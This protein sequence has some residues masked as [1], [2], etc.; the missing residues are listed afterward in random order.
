LITVSADDRT[1][2][3]LEGLLDL[4][5]QTMEIGGG[6]WVTMRARRVPKSRQRPHGVQY[7]LT[8]HRPGGTRIVGYDNAHAPPRASG[9][10]A[11]SRRPVAY[12]HIHRREAVA[13]Y[14]FESPGRLLE[15]F[16]AEVEAA[17]KREGIA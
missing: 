3:G 2:D 8:L 9:P 5:R 12:D 13:P 14:E 17:L 16:W 6:Y 15:D 4:D 1:W 10:A 7:A 11:R